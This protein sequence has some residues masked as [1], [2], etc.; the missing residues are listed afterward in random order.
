MIVSASQSLL[1]VL[2]TTSLVAMLSL[3]L[4]L[5]RFPLTLQPSYHAVVTF[6]QNHGGCFEYS[7]SKVFTPFLPSANHILMADLNLDLHLSELLACYDC[8]AADHDQR[9]CF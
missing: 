8:R 3:E 9:I 4:D 1:T 7:N 5:C 6:C 2:I